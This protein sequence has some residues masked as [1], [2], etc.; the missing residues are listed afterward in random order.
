MALT[1]SLRGDSRA[2]ESAASHPSTPPL[3]VPNDLR[4][5]CIK[6]SEVTGEVLKGE[7]PSVQHMKVQAKAANK[8]IA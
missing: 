6:A 8:S 7:S 4:L 5:I 2:N 3:A 1:L